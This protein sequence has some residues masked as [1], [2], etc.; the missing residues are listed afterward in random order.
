MQG[1]DRTEIL[2]QAVSAIGVSPTA[3]RK[4]ARSLM[5]VFSRL[6]VFP[7]VAAICGLLSFLSM[8][9]AAVPPRSL[10]AF[11]SVRVCVPFNVLISPAPNANQYQVLLDADAPVQ[12]ALQATVANNVLSL[13]VSGNFKTTQPIKLTVQ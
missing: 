8:A 6:A 11:N 12:Q 9:Q 13:G 5:A 2:R 3:I 4:R 1:C 10:P 7:V